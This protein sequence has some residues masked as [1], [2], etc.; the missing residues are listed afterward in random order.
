[1]TRRIALVVLGSFALCGL[2]GAVQGYVGPLDLMVPGIPSPTDVVK[3]IDAITRKDTSTTVDVNLGNT[4][5]QGKLLIARSRV[6][7]TLERSSR[8]WRGRV[9]VHL[10]VPSDISYSIDLAEIRPEHI[11]LDSKQ[12]TLIVQMPLPRVEDVVP[13]LG[14]VKTENKFKRCRFKRVDMSTSRELQNT[15]LKEDYL[16]RA[17]EKA[18]R[19]LPEIRLQ[20]RGALQAFLMRLLGGTSPGLTVVVE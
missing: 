16:A 20:G 9:T 1:M 10:T 6:D 13:V 12:R 3:L 19:Q 18:Q 4:V 2:G 15:M 7:V 5:S 14:D 17:R 8:N 11:R